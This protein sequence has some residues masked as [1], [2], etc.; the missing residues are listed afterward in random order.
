MSTFSGAA[1]PDF[2]G[3]APPPSVLPLAFA[4]EN[5][6]V[7][8]FG[9]LTLLS[10]GVGVTARSAVSPELCWGED[11]REFVT[12]GTA[13]RV[14]LPGVWFSLSSSMMMTSGDPWGFG[15]PLAECFTSSLATS[16]V[17]AV[18]SSPSLATSEFEACSFVSLP[19][20]FSVDSP[21]CEPDSSE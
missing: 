20:T 1:L 18:P 21:R 17:P 4:C 2:F 7:F 3:F 9:L 10:P 11:Q 8:G 16:T 14:G 19:T 6:P 13:A 15:E 12:F 5:K